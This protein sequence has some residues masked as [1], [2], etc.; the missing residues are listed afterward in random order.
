MTFTCQTGVESAVGGCQTGVARSLAGVACAS[1]V[2][3]LGHQ[4]TLLSDRGGK[5]SGELLELT[6]RLHYLISRAP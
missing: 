3:Q 2:L 1:Q 5:E 6:R 4:A